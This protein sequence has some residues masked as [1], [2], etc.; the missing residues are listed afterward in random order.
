MTIFVLVL[1]CLA[2][3]LF[4]L[5]ARDHASM[6]VQGWLLLIAGLGWGTTVG[7]AVK[8]VSDEHQARQARAAE[9]RR[10]KLIPRDGY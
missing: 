3:A 4:G 1:T 8:A 5:A 6:A 10:L 2:L 7:L 9:R